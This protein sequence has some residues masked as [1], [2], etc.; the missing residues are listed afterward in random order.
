MLFAFRPNVIMSRNVVISIL[1]LWH[2]NIFMRF[3]RIA[4]SEY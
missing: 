2:I 4:G 3:R 1:L